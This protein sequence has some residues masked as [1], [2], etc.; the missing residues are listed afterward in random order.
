VKIYR[1]RIM[2]L[3]IPFTPSLVLYSCATSKLEKINGLGPI[4]EYKGI[5]A[6]QTVESDDSLTITKISKDSS[7]CGSV[8]GL[9][10]DDNGESI[11][12][13]YVFV[14]ET[15][16]KTGCGINGSFCIPDI[17]VGRYFIDVGK[18]GYSPGRYGPIAVSRDATV[19]IDVHLISFPV[20]GVSVSEESEI[21]LN[22][23]DT[24]NKWEVNF[25][26]IEAMP[27]ETIHDILKACPGL[28]R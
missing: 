13:A 7:R 11:P 23:Y 17:P 4:H 18:I 8:A 5:I 1:M 16:I 9:V 25:R 3:L 28:C 20:R 26:W 14:E 10:T 27:G 15:N 21:R 22:K 19:T 12:G 24:S 6:A 2:I